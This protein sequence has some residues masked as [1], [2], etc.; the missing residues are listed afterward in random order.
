VIYTTL[1]ILATALGVV[2]SIA[3]GPM[4]GVGTYY[5]FAVLRPQYLWNWALPEGAAWSWYVAV[6]AIARTLGQALGVAPSR[7]ADTAHPDMG[8]LNVAHC[9]FLAFAGWVCL[10]YVFAYSQSYADR[11]FS[12]YQKIFVMYF[13]ASRAVRRVDDVWTLYILATVAVGYVA[14]ELN[15]RYLQQGFLDIYKRG[16]GGLD[17]NGAGLMIAMGIPLALFAWEGTRTRIRWVYFAFVPFMLH[18]VLMSYSRGAMLSLLVSAPLFWLR[19]SVKRYFTI[20]FVSLLLLVPSMA[21]DEIRAR[22]LTLQRAEEDASGNLRLR[23]WKAALLLAIDHPILGV[24]VRNAN[25][26]SYRYGADKEGRTIHSQY[27]QV[28]ADN[29]FVGLALYLAAFGTAWAMLLRA[30]RATAATLPDIAPTSWKA[31]SAAAGIE[32]SLA[33]YSVGSVFLSLETFELPYILLLLA[34]QL[35]AVRHPDDAAAETAT[36]GAAQAHDAASPRSPPDAEP[37]HR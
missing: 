34:A 24:G 18:A 2:G 1:M 9:A 10:S 12:E 4:W 30:R 36:E 31:R 14:Y 15:M 28:A 16:Y 27:L 26:F 29:G 32:T 25:L 7:S 17:N 6:A 23:S 35:G 37:S 3:S 13:V 33:V 20:A 22:F 21:G 19:S 5:F 8:R 11:Y